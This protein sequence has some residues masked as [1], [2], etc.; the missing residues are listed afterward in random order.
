MRLVILSLTPV[1]VLATNRSA[2]ITY[3]SCIMFTMRWGII[4]GLISGRKRVK[5]IFFLRGLLFV[6]RWLSCNV[7]SMDKIR[8]AVRHTAIKLLVLQ[9]FV[10][11]FTYFQIT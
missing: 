7:N 6:A 8:A 11:K 3:S 1:I 5:I 10:L 9:E 2:F 4:F